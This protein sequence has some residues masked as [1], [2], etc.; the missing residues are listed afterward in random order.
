MQDDCKECKQCNECKVFG[1]CKQCKM[2]FW[3]LQTM[4]G[5]GKEVEARS[6]VHVVHVVHVVRV[7]LVV[8]VVRLVHVVHVVFRLL[9][10]RLQFARDLVRN[11]SACSTNENQ[12]VAP[13]TIQCAPCMVCANAGSPAS[14]SAITA[15]VP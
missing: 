8:R 14:G 5:F 2:F 10:W 3:R 11:Q 4:H 1:N 6:V 7:V 9:F 15:V 13:C 12:L